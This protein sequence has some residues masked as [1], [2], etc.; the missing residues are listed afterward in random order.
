MNTLNIQIGSTCS[1]KFQDI[2]RKIK[3]ETSFRTSKLLSGRF[4]MFDPLEKQVLGNQFTFRL[5]DGKPG[6]FYYD[7]K[8]L[9]FPYTIVD[10]IDDRNPTNWVY[11]IMCRASYLSDNIEYKTDSR[12]FVNFVDGFPIQN[13]LDIALKGSA[14]VRSTISQM[15]KSKKDF[16]TMKS[17]WFAATK[18]GLTQ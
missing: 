15:Q 6:I 7:G 17:K 11:T 3:F 10:C 12:P 18:M 1:S 14:F 2:C 4:L 9:V 16:D 13:K 5:L 8:F